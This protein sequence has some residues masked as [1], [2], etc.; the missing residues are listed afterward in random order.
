MRFVSAELAGLVRR[1]KMTKTNIKC[2]HCGESL[3]YRVEDGPCSGLTIIVYC[4]NIDCPKFLV[5]FEKELFVGDFKAV[6]K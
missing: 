5:E 6:V 3:H 4:E 2:G 1:M